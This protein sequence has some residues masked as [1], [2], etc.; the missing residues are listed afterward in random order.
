M[1]GGGESG[2]TTAKAQG[3]KDLSRVVDAHLA[4]PQGGKR[5]VSTTKTMLVLSPQ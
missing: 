2:C 3:P 4:L 5:S 1:M